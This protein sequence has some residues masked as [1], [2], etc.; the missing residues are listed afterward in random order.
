MSYKDVIEKANAAYI[1]ETETRAL[2]VQ[3]EALDNLLAEKDLLPDFRAKAEAL[4]HRI[5]IKLCSVLYLKSLDNAVCEKVLNYVTAERPQAEEKGYKKT[6]AVMDAAAAALKNVSALCGRVDDVKNGLLYRGV[7]VADFCACEAAAKEINFVKETVEKQEFLNPFGENVAFVDVK[8]EILKS[9]NAALEEI[10]AMS[11]AAVKTA[12]SDYVEDIS[13]EFAL[14]EYYPL[15]DCDEGGRA[16][17]TVLCTPFKDEAKL[18]ATFARRDKVKLYYL[19]CAVF[20]KSDFFESV[21][22]F[23]KAE[24]A[25]CLAYGAGALNSKAQAEFLK[26]AMRF[27]KSS[28]QIFIS[29]ET[30]REIYSAALAAAQ[31]DGALSAVDISRTY[32]SMPAYKDVEEELKDKGMLSEP[33]DYER[34]KRMPFMGFVGLNKI[35]QARVQ[36]TKNW[37][38]VGI[39][40]SAANQ[41]RAE[42]YLKRLPSSYLLIDS[43]WGDYSKF[44]GNKEDGE[45][46][47]DYD[48]IKSVHIKNIRT[49]VESGE[50]VFAKCGMLAR[51]CTTAG[52]DRLEWQKLSKEEMQERLDMATKLVFKVLGVTEIV[53]EVLLLDN[54]E[55][56]TAG[57]L[58][59]DGGKQIQYK[60]SDM[61]ENLEW[62]MGCI[63][64]ES[65]HALQNKLAQG[66]WSKWYYDNMGITRGRVEQWVR[67]RKIYNHNT[68]SD[69]Y[70][71]HMYEGDARAFE[72]DCDDGRNY[73]WNGMDFEF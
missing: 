3:T 50:S 29:D 37:Y 65:F 51:Y 55:N 70:Q 34:L 56:P 44:E 40:L 23:L 6:V 21:F 27:G 66:G 2:A 72:A 64:H 41:E 62:A 59:V 58:C 22:T 1:R 26:S 39:R 45:K 48:G 43:G 7:Q 25:D 20:E 63:V 4:R 17:A 53:P 71:V 35:V 61:L 18:Y 60:Y 10:N 13:N 11:A 9:I 68:K 38:D 32:I 15:P 73:A 16:R 33:A 47:F 30:G 5:Y 42:R 19:N 36:G 12:I 49:I 14:C 57:G 67:T 46:E 54:L 28:G 31:T 24:N 8:A 69:V 52:G